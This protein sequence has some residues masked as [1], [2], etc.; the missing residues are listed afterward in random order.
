MI[1]SATEWVE[2]SLFLSVLT[3]LGWEN[4]KNAYKMRDIFTK[5]KTV[6]Y[7]Y[8]PAKR[9]GYHQ[10]FSLSGDT[11]TVRRVLR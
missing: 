7:F 11:D 10:F 1:V 8:A 3:G 9:E 6:L 5:N 2:L 4:F